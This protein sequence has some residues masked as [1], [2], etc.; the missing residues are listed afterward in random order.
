MDKRG[1]IRQKNGT[2]NWLE[3]GDNLCR[4]AAGRKGKMVRAA[5]RAAVGVL[6]VLLCAA[7]TGCQAEPAAA[8]KNASVKTVAKARMPEE[9]TYKTE[10]ERWEAERALQIPEHFNSAYTAFSYETASRILKDGQENLLYSPI[11]LYYTLALA[12]EG[13]GGETR[14]EILNILHYPY[15]E[16]LSADC[17]TA[18]EVLYKKQGKS[19]KKADGEEENPGSRYELTLCNSL[20]SDPSIKIKD[21]FANHA[22]QYFYSDIFTADFKDEKTG[23][24]M[25]EWVGEKTNSLINPDI[26]L[27]GNEILSLI[28]TVYFYDEWVNRFDREETEED[29]FTR[30]DGTEV[31]C[32]FMNMTL[33]SH[34]FRKGSGYTASSLSLKNGTVDFYLPDPG[35]NVHELLETP[36]RLKSILE[37]EGEDKMGEVVWKVP[38]FSYGSKISLKAALEDLGMKRAFGDADFSNMTDSEAFISNVRQE[39]HIGFDENGVEAAAFTEIL[40]C[41]AAMPEG[42][43]EMVLDRP[44]LYV[45][46]NKGQVLFIGICEDPSASAL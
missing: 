21:I 16:N 30:G 24:A 35:I 36:K 37:G 18:Y 33:G 26:K 13:A 27:D 43:A 25:A 20:W 9:K 10:E 32:D 14:K 12:A 28:N 11:S 31:T 22:A 44:F 39:T 46:K 34:G 5:V 19:V 4:P 17:K 1:E 38:K 8:D 6:T 2:G 40:Y 15:V 23:E 3:A 42:R 45:I 7:L 41:G 29:I